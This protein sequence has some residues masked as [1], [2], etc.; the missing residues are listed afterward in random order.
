M[1]RSAGEIAAQ[2]LKAARGA[3]VPL[4]VA[5]DLARMAAT[6]APS[7]L[8]RLAEALDQPE[9][10]GALCDMC[11]EADIAGLEPRAM[12]FGTCKPVTGARDVD[13]PVWDQ[14]DRLA[15]RTF[16]PE[17][18]ASRASGAGAGDID[19]D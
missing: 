18:A 17:T 14:L 8:G 13:G 2:V 16:V 11:V 15:R 12:A 1:I 19:N 3:G 5:E 6:L 4:G 10:H 9:R 7:D